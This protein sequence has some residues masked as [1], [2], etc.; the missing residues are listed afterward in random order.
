[1]SYNPKLG[2]MSSPFGENPNE[3]S[4]I[5]ADPYEMPPDESIPSNVING[6]QDIAN[7]M[8][9]AYGGLM[10]GHNKAQTKLSE[11]FSKKPA[12]EKVTVKTEVAP[13]PKEKVEAMD[14][15]TKNATIKSLLDSGMKIK[16]VFDDVIVAEVNGK[17]I[18]ISDK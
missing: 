14:L 12:E 6:P 10:D 7:M 9:E 18:Y 15:D 2:A 1:M 4:I 17:E 3:G 5:Q 13:Q 16:N 8:D 11:Q